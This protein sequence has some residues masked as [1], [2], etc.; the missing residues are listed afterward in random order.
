MWQ[1]RTEQIVDNIT[2]IMGVESTG[3]CL[4]FESGTREWIEPLVDA[5]RSWKADQP[6]FASK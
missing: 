1:D 4:L 5:I 6:Q 2:I 3:E